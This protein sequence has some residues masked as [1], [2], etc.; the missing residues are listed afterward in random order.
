MTLSSIGEN[1]LAMGG[2]P[3]K[4]HDPTAYLFQNI[5]RVSS[6]PDIWVFINLCLCFTYK[7]FLQRVFE[8]FLLSIEF[9]HF[10]MHKNS[11]FKDSSK[12]QVYFVNA[13]HLSKYNL[14]LHHHAHPSPLHHDHQPLPHPL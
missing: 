3:S 1:Y 11:L 12:A 5:G 8:W 13:F 4:Y 10:N 7:T 9:I 6:S 2:M 14:L